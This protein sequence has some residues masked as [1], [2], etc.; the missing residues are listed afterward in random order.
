MSSSDKIVHLDSS[1]YRLGPL[2]HPPVISSYLILDREYAIVDCGPQSVIEELFSLISKCG[3][4]LSEIDELLLTHIH[5]DHAGGAAKFVSSCKSAGIV[6][7]ERGLRH[8]LDPTTLN[9]SSRSVLRERIFNSWGECQPVPKE[10]LTAIKPRGEMDLGTKVL[11]YLPATGHAPHHNVLHSKK[12]SLVFSADSL[13]IFEQFSG[14]IIP[15]TPPPSFDFD[16]AIL[17]IR[18]V[19]D[20]DPDLVCPAHFVEIRPDKIYFSRV[21]ERFVQW[22]RILSSYVSEHKLENYQLNDCLNGFSILSENFPE[23]ENLSDDL[24]EQAARVDV[25]GFLDYFVRQRMYLGGPGA[26]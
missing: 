17:D 12:D 22:G 18:M 26:K 15:T 8:L 1:I 13:G 9:S 11:Q 25:G 7:P 6:V 19:K 14:S 24:K 5:L 10:K 2:G 3:I 21:E 20:L 16:Q 4:S 23:Y